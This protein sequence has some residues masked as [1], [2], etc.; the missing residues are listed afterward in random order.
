MTGAVSPLASIEEKLVRCM[1][2]GLC[3]AACPIYKE[4]GIESN[5]ARGRLRLIKGVLRK[6]IPLT[7]SL[8]SRIF[9]CLLCKQ[10][11]TACPSGI[12]VDT[13]I[14]AAREEFAGGGFAPETMLA[15]SRAVL[16]QKNITGEPN[17][18]RD[19]WSEGEAWTERAARRRQGAEVVFF[20]GCVSSMFPQVYGIPRAVAQ[21]L[22]AA[23]VE[24]ATLGGEE[25]CCGFPLIIGGMP[26]AAAGIAT[27]NVEAMR[28]IGAKKLVA[29]CPSCFHTWKF[30]Y[31]ELLGGDLGFEVVHSSEMLLE[32]VE[33]GRIRPGPWEAVATY[34]DPCDLG[35]KSGVYDPPRRLLKS[36]PGIDL[37][38]M[39]ASR[40]AT[41]CCGGGG[42]MEANFPEMVHALAGKKV[43]ELAATGASLVASSCQQCKRTIQGAVKREKA[44]LKVLDVSEVLVKSLGG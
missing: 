28:K 9:L 6:E 22:D 10:C 33:R 20:T 19:L 5:L 12:E 2:C 40:D 16:D 23:G 29:A 15:L 7:R 38:E 37:R 41:V 25:W 18:N 36:I 21:L 8:A 39:K 14:K 43:A 4:T 24:F 31:P 3:R 32:L 42:N 44:R 11:V 30:D 35:R 13:I 27:A 34:H 26:G 17:A 1:K